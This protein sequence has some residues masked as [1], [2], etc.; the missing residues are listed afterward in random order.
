MNRKE[1]KSPSIDLVVKDNLLLSKKTLVGIRIWPKLRFQ[2]LKPDTWKSLGHVA[3]KT[4]GE[5]Q[6]LSF[7]PA[8]DQ[9]D[10]EVCR[11]QHSHLH[12]EEQD[13]EYGTPKEILID[14]KHIGILNNKIREIHDLNLNNGLRWGFSNC[15]NLTAYLLNLSGIE[16]PS[17]I[18]NKVAW[19]LWCDGI[20]KRRMGQ[21]LVYAPL[22][23]ILIKYLNPLLNLNVL[24]GISRFKKRKLRSAEEA[25]A[26]SHLPIQIIWFFLKQSGIHA[27]QFLIQANNHGAGIEMVYRLKKI[28]I[29][30]IKL[31][32]F[33]FILIR[34]VKND[35]LFLLTPED[36]YFIVSHLKTRLISS[37]KSIHNNWDEL[38]STASYT[39]KCS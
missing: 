20:F 28:I 37:P 25:I 10:S 29:F 30:A 12:T 17:A 32:T 34:F 31:L 27:N 23:I 36:I 18:K 6:Y 22:L 3:I 13:S 9:S 1:D 21:L 16:F 19:A 4:Y 33:V 8:C 26:K 7:W 35:L 2:T 38:D 5:G 11:Y 39:L 24:F 14:V 15:S